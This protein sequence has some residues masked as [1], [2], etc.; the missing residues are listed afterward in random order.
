MGRAGVGRVSA[1][2]GLAN[3]FFFAAKIPTKIAILAGHSLISTTRQS[4]TQANDGDV[5]KEA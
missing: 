5:A 2:R 3:F 1:R 4:E